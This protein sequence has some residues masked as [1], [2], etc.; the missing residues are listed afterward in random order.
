VCPNCGANQFHFD[1][2]EQTFVC[3]FCNTEVY[4]VQEEK[5]KPEPVH[6]KPVPEIRLEREPLRCNPIEETDDERDAKLREHLRNFV[7]RCVVGLVVIAI[8]LVLGNIEGRVPT[9]SALTGDALKAYMLL[10]RIARLLLF[11]CGIGSVTTSSFKFMF[12]YIRGFKDEVQ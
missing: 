12:G 3:E 9:L 4:G 1:E 8:A 11:L 10:F 2:K 6:T 7:Y 5:K